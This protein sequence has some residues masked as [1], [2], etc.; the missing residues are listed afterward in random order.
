MRTHK[1]TQNVQMKLARVVVWFAFY[2]ISFDVLS[3]EQSK[4][5]H[6]HHIWT[7]MYSPVYE[8]E[9][10]FQVNELG[11][12]AYVFCVIMFILYTQN[13]ILSVK[14]YRAKQRVLTAIHLFHIGVTVHKCMQCVLSHARAH[15]LVW[16]DFMSSVW[17]QRGGVTSAAWLLWI[18][19][20]IILQ[21]S[22]CQTPAGLHWL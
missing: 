8:T 2:L 9:S 13:M 16:M 22:L 14:M 6:T 1:K 20:V 4:H 19:D 17:R 18:Y 7:D 11:L 10:C 15:L 21:M 3:S 5:S 12:R